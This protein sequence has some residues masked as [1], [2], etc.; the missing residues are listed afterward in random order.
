MIAMWTY[1]YTRVFH[2]LYYVTAFAS[3]AS[4]FR[5]ILDCGNFIFFYY[6]KFVHIFYPAWWFSLKAL[7]PM[8]LWLLESLCPTFHIQHFVGCLMLSAIFWDG[9]ICVK[10]IFVVVYL[11]YLSSISV[12][13]TGRITLQCSVYHVASLRSL[14]LTTGKYKYVYVYTCICEYINWLMK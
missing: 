11:L 10:R 2:L 13:A 14:P 3:F 4:A 1:F 9:S 5:L 6:L 8:S 7:S 12:S